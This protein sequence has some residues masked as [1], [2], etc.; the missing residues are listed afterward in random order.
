MTSFKLKLQQLAFCKMC[1]KPGHVTLGKFPAWSELGP[2]CSST[3]SAGRAVAGHQRA[4]GLH[5]A[6]PEEGP[7]GHRGCVY[8]VGP[9]GT[10]LWRCGL[11]QSACVALSVLHMLKVEVLA[12]L[13]SLC[14]NPGAVFLAVQK[15]DTGCCG[16]VMASAP[17]PV[18]V[19]RR[20]AGPALCFGC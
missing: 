20:A 3:K 13:C 9:R 11:G 12:S 17:S 18:C 2:S 16:W 4:P 8:H 7:W 10:L 6:A 15:Q 19:A 5:G 14:T 1:R